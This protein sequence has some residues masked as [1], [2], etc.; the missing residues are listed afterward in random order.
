M[1]AISQLAHQ[2]EK[3][4]T[5]NKILASFLMSEYVFVHETIIAEVDLVLQKYLGEE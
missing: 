3:L 2:V 4:K 1:D 5:E